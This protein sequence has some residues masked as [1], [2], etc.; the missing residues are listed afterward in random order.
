ME[1][2]SRP[3]SY[4]AIKKNTTLGQFTGELKKDNKEAQDEEE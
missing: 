4:N 2:K 1:Q 3:I